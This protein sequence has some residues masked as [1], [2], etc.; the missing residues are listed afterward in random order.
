MSTVKGI[1]IGSWFQRTTLHLSEVYDFLTDGAS[2]L[3]LDRST[4]QKLRADLRIASVEDIHDDFE[5]IQVFTKDNISLRMY[6]DGLILLGYTATNLIKKDIALLA[7]YYENA[8]SASLKYIFSLG[9][10]IP[11]ELANIKT[12]Y[13]YFVVLEDASEKEIEQL[14]KEFGQT[15]HFEVKKKTFEIYRGDTLYIINAKGID[16]DAIEQF[17]GEQ[18]FIREFKSQMHRYLNLHRVIWE[19]IAAVKER[20]TIRGKEIGEFKEKIEGYQ[21]TISMIDT[22]ISQMGTYIHTR[23][24]IVRGSAQMEP[25][26][27]VMQ[28][29]HETLNDTL[30]YVKDIWQMTKTYVDSALTVFGDLQAKAT[31]SSIQNLTVVTS[32]GVGATL[33]GLFSNTELPTFKLAGLFYFALLAFVGWLVS[34]LM[35]FF[36][37]RRVYVIKDSKADKDIH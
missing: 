9:A 17:I 21:K 32:M 30:S 24:A 5:Y 4:L 26:A 16:L 33:L 27:S 7:E 10:P 23:G 29:K 28:F 20:G 14:L 31:N 18:I 3:N 19:N 22:R 12:V 2:P 34:R 8:L 13:P 1:Y 15:K 6:E 35:K 36:A 37:M 11:K 25:F